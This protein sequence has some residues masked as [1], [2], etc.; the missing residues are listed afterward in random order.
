MNKQIRIKKRRKTTNYTY[1]RRNYIDRKLI[2]YF[3]EYIKKYHFNDKGYPLILFFDSIYK[4]INRTL[5][6]EHE[7]LITEKTLFKYIK[8]IIIKNNIYCI[9]LKI[10]K[11]TKKWEILFEYKPGE[12]P[13][14]SEDQLIKL[15]RELSKDL[16]N[17]K[18][19]K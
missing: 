5:K 2:V 16:T 11:R 14:F 7:K 12:L 6:N 18:N 8:R 17:E 19:E 4:D 3:S 13:S 1:S 10:N 9:I 15:D